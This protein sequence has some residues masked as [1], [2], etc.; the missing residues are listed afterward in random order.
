[1][2]T[3]YEKTVHETKTRGAAVNALAVVGFIALILL[4]MGLAIYAARFMPAAL[5]GI[6]EAAVS[7]SDIFSPDRPND[8][9]VVGDGYE[10]N[11][12]NVVTLPIGTSTPSGDADPAT[13]PST[14]SYTPPATGGPYYVQ[15]APTYGV[16]TI[17]TGGSTA[18]YYGDPDLTVEIL[19]VGYLRDKGDLDSFVEDDRIP[20][21]KDGAVKFRLANRGTNESGR[22]ELEIKVKTAG[23]TDTD[24]VTAPSMRPGTSVISFG[25]FDS[26]R[27]GD[28][29]ITLEVDPDDDVDESNERNNDDSDEVTVRS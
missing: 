16:I 20:R 25:V 10:N 4:G 21:N 8:I 2:E 1:M 22:F 23:G 24:T 7:L 13:T 11:G 3:T 17:P 6:G 29:D 19:A 26:N 9:E 12:G 5:S 28:V 14:P 15:P 18:N 27:S